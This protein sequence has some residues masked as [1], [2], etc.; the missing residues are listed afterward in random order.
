MENKKLLK[1]NPFFK[2]QDRLITKRYLNRTSSDQ[3][4]LTVADADCET[5]PYLIKD[6]LSGIKIS[7]FPYIYYHQQDVDAINNWYKFK[8]KKLSVQNY[9]PGTGVIQLIQLCLLTFAEKDDNIILNTPAYKP[10]ISSIISLGLNLIENKLVNINQEYH[11]DF[12][13]LKQQIIKYRPKVY[14]FCNPHNPTGKVFSKEDLVKLLKLA[15]KYNFYLVSDEI[16]QDIFYSKNFT[17]L[18]KAT[19]NDDLLQYAISISSPATTFNFFTIQFG[20]LLSWSN[21]IIDQLKITDN[22]LN[23]YPSSSFFNYLLLKSA[24]LNPKNKKWLKYKVNYLKDSFQ[25]LKNSIESKTKIIVTKSEA[26]TLA[27]LDFSNLVQDSNQL[28][29]RFTKIGIF[30][31]FGIDFGSDYRFFVRLNYFL[32]KNELKI[33]V[34]KLIKEF[35]TT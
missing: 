21:K 30:P 19:N 22:K 11:I 23:W 6:L 28:K 31:L 24:Y 8:Q 27:W 33:L 13:L 1:F 15:K 5:S 2:N 3:F 32:E 17:P 29:E 4:H 7:V 26:T 14:I 12:Y 9:L 25:Y 34:N 18:I 10:F 20:Y 16:W 35:Y